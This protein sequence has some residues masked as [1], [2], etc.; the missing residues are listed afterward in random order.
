MVHLHIQ[1]GGGAGDFIFNYFT[2]KY[3]K[4]LPEIKRLYPETTITCIAALHD[5]SST[6]LVT[7]NPHVDSIMIY[8]WY[9]PG[10]VKELAWKS[11]L[12]SRDLREFVDGHQIPAVAD[13]RVYLTAREEEMLDAIRAVGP[14]VVMHPFAG[15]P[16]R[17][18][19]PHPYDGKYKCYPD[20]KYIES[21]NLLAEKGYQVFFIGRSNNCGSDALRCLVAEELVLPVGVNPNVR[22]L[23][24]KLSIR[25]NVELVRNAQGFMGSHSSMLSAAWTN[26]VPSVFFYP[27]YD[28]HG[29]Y[30]SVIDHGGTTGTWALGQPQNKYFELSSEAFLRLDSVEPVNLLLSCMGR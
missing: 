4:A 12:S 3:W 7:T 8:P 30:R 1:A 13:H 5:S 20:Y 14:Y 9:P 26:S 10:H 16:H 25:M 28:E 24:N 15:L 29:N 23:V 19:F 22:S 17:G 18:A 27:A 11:L 21:A 2:N 6:E